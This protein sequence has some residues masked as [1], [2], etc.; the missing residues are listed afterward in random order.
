MNHE[1]EQVAEMYNVRH[2]QKVHTD[3]WIPYPSVIVVYVI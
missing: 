2:V 3:I 1:S